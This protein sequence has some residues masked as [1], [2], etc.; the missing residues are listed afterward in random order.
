[1]TDVVHVIKHIA[2]EGGGWYTTTNLEF[3]I[4]SSREDAEKAAAAMNKSAGV[5][6]DED[7]E[8]DD[9]HYT[10]QSILVLN[11]LLFGRDE[12]G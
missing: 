8:W 10:V 4:L 7:G 3:A 5:E 9:P 1:M 11:P 2:S 6:P 12:V